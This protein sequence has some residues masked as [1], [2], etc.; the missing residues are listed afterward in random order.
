VDVFLLRAGDQ[1]ETQIHDPNPTQFPQVG[2]FWTIEVSGHSTKVDLDKGRAILQAIDVPI[3]DWGN[4]Q[5]FIVRRRARPDTEVGVVESNLERHTHEQ[6]D[7][8]NTD[9]VFGGFERQFV[10][11]KAQVEWTTTVGNGAY[12]SQEETQA[13]QRR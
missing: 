11:N 1:A 9:S 8:R 12:F 4:G 6:A 7:I 3:L 10:R 2:L 5:N 13:N